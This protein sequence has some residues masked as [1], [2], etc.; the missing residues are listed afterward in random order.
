MKNIF[1]NI[2]VGVAI[3]AVF[4]P[5]AVF[6]Q[7]NLA[8]ADNPA[9][10]DT[11]N[12]ANNTGFQ[13]V[14]CSGAQTGA[15]PLNPNGG[16]TVTGCDFAAFMTLVQRGINF[17]LYASVFIAVIL[18]VVAGFNYLTAG[19]DTNKIKK[20][21]AIFKAVVIGMIIA[22]CSWLVVYTVLTAVINTSF[23]GGAS[24]IIPLT[25]Q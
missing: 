9:T 22:F 11:S 16:G 23:G 17:L 5:Y 13:L 3:T 19:G 24:N 21:H 10:F 6:A 15:D 25:K 14:P 4:V 8:P 2:F 1:K 18:I 12:A 20:A 7:T